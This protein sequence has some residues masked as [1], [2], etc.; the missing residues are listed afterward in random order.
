HLTPLAVFLLSANGSFAYWCVSGMESGLFSLLV[1]AAC[2]VYLLAESDTGRNNMPKF[3]T[4]SLLL[5]LSA[6]TRPEGTLFLALVVLHFLVRRLRSRDAQARSR[7]LRYGLALVIPFTL[8]VAPLYVWRLTYY[9]YLFPNTFYAKTGLSS[10]YLKSGIDYLVSFY[11]AY[12][13][14][15]LGLL[16]PVL[17]AIRY[18]Q[19]APRTALSFVLLVVVVH[20]L[21]TISVGG[22]VLRIYRFFVPVYFLVY[23]LL[24]EG[25]WLSP[26]PRP[27]VPVLLLVLAGLTFWG[28]F[29]PGK[30][31]RREINHNKYLEQGLV[32]KMRSTGRWLNA[33]LTEQDW[34]CCTTIGA[35][36][37][38]SDRNLLDMLGLTD[39]VIAHEP[40]NILGSRVYWKERNYNTRHLLERNPAYVYFST[41][42]KPSAAAERALFLRTRFRQGYFACPVS[43]V[44]AGR[45]YSDI[46]FKRRPGAESLP[47]ETPGVN[48]E[49]IDLYNLGINLARPARYDTALATFRR[50]NQI[51]PPDFAYA[52]EWIGQIQLDMKQED[53]ALENLYRAISINDWCITAHQLLGSIYYQ[54]REY[55]SAAAHFDKVVR[56]APDYF[57]G[58][59][60]LS[61][62]RNQTRDFAA[63]ETVLTA[64]IR[65]FPA[66][67]DLVLRLAYVRMMGGR[68]DAA[69]QDLNAILARSPGHRE[70]RELLEQVRRRRSGGVLP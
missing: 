15:G 51:A 6:L 7:L 48:P 61:A 10:S 28:P 43:V 53:P 60:N 59:I 27:A 31:V 65:K 1:A 36:G 52:Y 14:W 8:V 21:Y 18:R 38:F 24:A 9:G 2:Y 64:G 17:V 55:D 29:M 19:R 45:V 3:V 20:A 11:K 4:A 25:L 33:N 62:A 37:Y 63:A 57:E 40:E 39:A 42:G 12:G 58:Y 44:E 26:L 41:G 69:E 34:F 23:F 35:V 54:R 66:I 5:G 16:V 46:L 67:P 32:M 30:S 47:V 56:Y 68:L 49:F 70:A 50:C 13:F 22:D